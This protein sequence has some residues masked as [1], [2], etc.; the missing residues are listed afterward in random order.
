[1][2]YLKYHF[3]WVKDHEGGVVVGKSEI[4]LM[5]LKFLL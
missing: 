1:M 2:D 4:A 3:M 5:A